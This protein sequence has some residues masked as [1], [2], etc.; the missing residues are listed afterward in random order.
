MSTQQ[1]FTATRPGPV[2]LNL[3]VGHAKTIVDPAL[4]YA[5]I[6]VSTTD[7]SGPAAEAVHATCSRPTTGALDIA[8]PQMP[9]V[10]MTQS[11]SAY[12]FFGGVQN[13]INGITFVNSQVVNGQVVN[14]DGT[15]PITVTAYLPERST[16]VF[17]S[18]AAD[19]E[20]TGG[21]E[22]LATKTASG[23]V[24]AQAVL[25]LEATSL[26]GAVQAARV[27]ESVQADTLSG[28]ITIDHYAGRAARLVS[29]SGALDLTAA[30]TAHGPLHA[31]T[32]SG[33]ITLRGTGALDTHANSVSGRVHRL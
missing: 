6:E 9:G 10:R 13:T 18:A 22:H 11:N 24:T 32:V 2:A 21:I 29:V 23:A 28:T 8:V 4:R 19:L 17:E 7:D 3:P 1:T 30:P 27:F 20:A 33:A 14:G 16:F 26:S 15:S 25:R 31:E 5:R 12:N